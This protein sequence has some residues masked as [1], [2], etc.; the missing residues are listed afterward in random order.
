MKV[1]LRNY[2]EMKL[3]IILSANLFRDKPYRLPLIFSTFYHP[4]H[5][6]FVLYVSAFETQSKGYISHRINSVKRVITSLHNT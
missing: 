3:R 5:R 1:R 4:S 2:A 6:N